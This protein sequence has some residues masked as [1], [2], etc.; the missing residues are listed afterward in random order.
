MSLLFLLLLF[1]GQT[2]CQDFDEFWMNHF[3]R[4]PKYSKALRPPQPD[5]VPMDI[6]MV[7]DIYYIGET[8]LEISW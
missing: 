6:S 1:L 7:L 4:L 3:D 5:G 8:T 2:Q